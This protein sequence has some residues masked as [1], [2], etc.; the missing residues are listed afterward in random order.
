[1]KL[2][3]AIKALGNAG[4]MPKQR[5]AK[6]AVGNG[7]P[8]KQAKNRTPDR[9]AVN[10][11]ELCPE[12]AKLEKTL[13]SANPISKVAKG[14]NDSANLLNRWGRADAH[15]LGW[16][17]ADALARVRMGEKFARTSTQDFSRPD[18]TTLAVRKQAHDDD[19]VLD[20]GCSTGQTDHLLREQDRKTIAKAHGEAGV[21]LRSEYL[22]RDSRDELD[23]PLD[24]GFTTVSRLDG[25][26]R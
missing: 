16:M 13:E 14:L 11:M 10:W 1:M 9:Q 17:E 24:M 18:P 20:Q 3:E 8:S 2:G 5:T 21:S 4:N 23:G 26:D 19:F 22:R 6:S 25:K 7:N 15:T 12:L